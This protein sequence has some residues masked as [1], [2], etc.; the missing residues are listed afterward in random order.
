MVGIVFP[1][2]EVSSDSLPKFLFFFIFGIPRVRVLNSELFVLI[3]LFGIL[4][5]TIS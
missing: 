4:G 2:Q 5:N 1:I 3:F